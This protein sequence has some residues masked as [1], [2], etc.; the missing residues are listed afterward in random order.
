MKLLK[1]IFIRIVL[2]IV[3]I[4]SGC[5]DRFEEINT[6]PNRPTKV[7]T[8]GLFNG[9]T[10]TIVGS[11]TRGAFGSARM[12]L[13]WMQYSAQLNYTDE[14][15]F[16]FRETVN[17][18][19]FNTY[20]IEALNFKS[21]LDLNTNPATASE[22]TTYGNQ[23]N[24]IAAARIMLAYNFHKLVDAYG[25]IPYYSFGNDDPDFQALDI[26]N[27]TPKFASQQKIYTDILKELKEAVESI[28]LN[29]VIFYENQDIIFRNAEKLKR[30]GNSLRLR[31][32][33]RVKNT[34]PA[35]AIHIQ[36]AIASGIML[37]NADSVGV[38]FEDNMINPAP[39]YYSFFIDNRTDFTASK[40]F[41]DLLKG[42]IGP[43]SPD[44]RLQKII[45]PIGTTKKNSLHKNYEETSD[46]TRYQGMPYG[47]SSQLTTSQVSGVSLFS[48]TIFRPDY[49]EYL[50]EYSEVAFLLSEINGWNQDYYQKGVQASMKKWGVPEDQITTYINGLPA[51]NQKN[52]LTQK[53][54]ALFMQPYE[55]WA[56]YRRTGY[57][58]IL[59]KPG[60]TG[61]LVNPVSGTLTYTFTPLV[62]LTE[63]P[64]RLT[65][66]VNLQDLNTVEYYHAAQN[67]GGDQLNTKLIW[68][69]N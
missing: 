21:I 53:Y 31:I 46:L 3:F 16:L 43:F 28:D 41:I 11:A 35:A 4:F 49:T 24:Q 61:T 66:P 57:P 63:M 62:N 26:N 47:I 10:K 58:D 64:A 42:Q 23:A 59:I 12:T 14:D 54:I 20:Y 50:M 18:H 8:P 52:V 32:A 56:E 15:R 51:A 33:N 25:D 2:L 65:Y 17:L 19:L 9:A 30:F 22:M 6:D 38:T 48:A 60:E 39:T 44:P 67:I 36:E 55:A 68:D 1:S 7:S 27:P 40:T 13:P 34:I 29:D 37:S 45:A 5:T 69:T